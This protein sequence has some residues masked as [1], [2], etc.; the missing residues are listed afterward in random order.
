[1][2]ELV[3]KYEVV[4]K[5][6]VQLL[7]SGVTIMT[8]EKVVVDSETEEMKRA[9]KQGLIDYVAVVEPKVE[10][11]PVIP[12]SKLR[13]AAKDLGVKDHA[14]KPIVELK[15]LVETKVDGTPKKVG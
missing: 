11:K 4:G 13:E 8:G 1:V 5:R 6:N 10:S 2:I 12:E 7:Q 15:K 14:T 9:K 3:G